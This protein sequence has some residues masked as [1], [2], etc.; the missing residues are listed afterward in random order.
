MKEPI[1][2]N[3]AVGGRLLG[4]IGSGGVAGARFR[5]LACSCGWDGGLQQE[6]WSETLGCTHMWVVSVAK[7]KHQS[8]D[9]VE[10][11]LTI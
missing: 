10:P 8:N 11:R 7:A 3:G 1:R 9:T 6:G 5:G 4:P 2:A